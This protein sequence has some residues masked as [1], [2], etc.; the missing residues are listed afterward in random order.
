MTVKLRSRAPNLDDQAI[1]KIVEII[2]GWSNSKLTWELL[3]E[4]ILLRHRVAYTR[5]AL[6]NHVRIK[7]A[8]SEC[9]QKLSRTGFKEQKALS[10]EQ[11]QI[12][13]LKAENERLK[14]E[15]NNLLEQFNRWV[16]NGYLKT[17]DDR[18]REFM[19]TPLPPVNREPSYKS[20]KIN[21]TKNQ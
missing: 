8:F 19:N 4:Q 1:E 10:P 17:M 5:Q 21:I 15:N 2:D 14:R 7:D 12:A 13:R 20:N 3:I 16:Y 9:K 6:H 18:M 11:Q